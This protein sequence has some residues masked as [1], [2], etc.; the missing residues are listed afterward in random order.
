MT[1]TSS[2]VL[3]VREIPPR[4]KHPTIHAT[5]DG[6]AAAEIVPGPSGQRR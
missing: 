1:P 2:I 5:F 6:L 4:D 3:D